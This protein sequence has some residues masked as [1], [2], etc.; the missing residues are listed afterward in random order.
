MTI[1]PHFIK[2]GS[3][4]M[5]PVFLWIL[6]FVILSFILFEPVSYKITIDELW[7]IALNTKYSVLDAA[8]TYCK[9]W[10]GRFF[11]NLYNAAVLNLLGWNLN[12]YAVYNTIIFFLLYFATFFLVHKSKKQHYLH[13]QRLNTATTATVLPILTF[14][15]FFRDRFEIFYWISSISNHLL[16]FILLGF[17]VGLIL[18]GRKGSNLIAL[19]IISISIGGLNEVY[20]ICYFIFLLLVAILSKKASLL[21]PASLLLPVIVFSYLSAGTAIRMNYLPEMN[22]IASI[23][24]TILSIW[25]RIISPEFFLTIL[26][27]VIIFKT[28]SINI[29]TTFRNKKSYNLTLVGLLMTGIASIWGHCLIL[30]DTCPARGQ[31]IFFICVIAIVCLLLSKQTENQKTKVQW[32]K[33]L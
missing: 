32:N 12:L 10:N 22:W 7:F 9:L 21:I 18:M 5:L 11:S 25:N 24:F 27:L 23:K 16:S 19:A 29:K 31:L 26:L 6:F 2:T 4:K 8:L 20:A 13:F 33:D 30:G 14:V 1:N 28:G 17:A 15:F 3:N